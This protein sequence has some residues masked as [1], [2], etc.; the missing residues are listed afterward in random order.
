MM[1]LKISGFN[2]ISDHKTS[3]VR[4]GLGNNSL[5]KEVLVNS[6]MTFHSK[7]KLDDKVD[8]AYSE[9]HHPDDE[10]IN[11]SV[12]LSKGNID[13][14]CLR[15]REWLTSDVINAYGNI[16]NSQFNEDV[17]VFSTFFYTSL[18]NRGVDDMKGWTRNVN[19]FL[20]EFVFF[21]IHE[22]NH[23][24][25]IYLNNEENTLNL[26]DPYDQQQELV[27]L[28]HKKRIHYILNEFL[29]KHSDYPDSVSFSVRIVKDIPK[30]RNGYDCGVFLLAF[31]KYIV[32]KK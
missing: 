30:Q 8:S 25:L 5:L 15:D 27:K 23:W 26:L 18:L 28:E 10:I 6:R 20:K 7:V 1:K 24:Y 31:M 9:F 21:P 11:Q 12:G 17:F 32:L 3:V 19:I 14:S 4:I 2:F 16:L 29:L 22:H 13:V